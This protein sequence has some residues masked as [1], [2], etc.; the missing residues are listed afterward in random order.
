M[1]SV[2]LVSH[3]E[4][5]GASRRAIF[6]IERTPSDVERIPSDACRPHV[7]ALC[8]PP[9]AGHCYGK[10]RAR[11]GLWG[12]LGVAEE[13]RGSDRHA[14]SCCGT[15]SRRRE[16]SSTRRRE[17]SPTRVVQV[18]HERRP[19]CRLRARVPAVEPEAARRH[20]FHHR[21]RRVLRVLVISNSARW[22]IMAIPS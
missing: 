1:C 21:G 14:S 12:A 16:A 6:C 2:Q 15:A 5:K 11:R 17:R 4:W 9:L 7:T 18:H 10:G 13:G 22:Y 3:S 20:P 19:H 8:A